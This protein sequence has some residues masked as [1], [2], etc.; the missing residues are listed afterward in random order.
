MHCISRVDDA[1]V[2]ACTAEGCGRTLQLRRGALT[3]IVKGDPAAL[4]G[5]GVGLQLSVRQ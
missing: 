4:H 3:V 5:S 2:Y 1:T